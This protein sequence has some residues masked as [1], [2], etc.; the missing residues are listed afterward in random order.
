MRAVLLAIVAFG[1]ATPA[2][3][4][5]VD[6]QPNGFAVREEAQIA[7]PPDKVYAAIGRI[8]DWWSSD[9]T[10]SRDA[11]NLSLE[12]RAGGCQCERLKDGGTAHHMT[13]LM[14]Q[15]G[16]SLLLEG[17]LGPHSGM[18]GTGHMTYDLTPKDGG[19]TL[20]VSYVFGG[21]VEGGLDKLAGPVDGV[22]GAQVERL[23][24][25]VE[26]GAP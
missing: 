17:A 20:V 18:G 15:P 26:T 19:T 22:L 8:G 25:Y 1:L 6:S 13:V 12:L 11:K 3:A 2:T 9:H 16:V 10:W 14:A 7:A 21:Y 5:V 24:R 4:A 23:K